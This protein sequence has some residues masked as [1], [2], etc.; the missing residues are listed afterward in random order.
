MGLDEMTYGESMGREEEKRREGKGREGKGR[1]GKGRE[2]KG[3]LKAWHMPTF[4]VNEKHCWEVEKNST[5][6]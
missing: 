5:E 2:G 4:R 6:K 3:D 1:E